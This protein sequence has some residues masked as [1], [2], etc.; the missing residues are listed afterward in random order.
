MVKTILPVHSLHHAYIVEG[1]VDTSRRELHSF[2][3]ENFNLVPGHADMFLFSYPDLGVSNVEEIISA[4]LRKPT[5][6]GRKVLIID[7]VSIS[8]QAQN[9][10]LKTLEE[11]Q[12]HTHIFLLTQTSSVFLPTVLSRVHVVSYGNSMKSV[13]IDIQERAVTFLTSSHAER[14]EMIKDMLKEKDD[15]EIGEEYIQTFVFELERQAHAKI[16]TKDLNPFL[17]LDEYIRDASSSNKLLLEYTALTLPR[18][19]KS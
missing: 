6:G 10:L 18:V 4:N 7:F 8:N 9:S 1:D 15:E 16:E 2:L 14:L 17:I 13:D 12:Q 3:K 11:P 5:A 19:R